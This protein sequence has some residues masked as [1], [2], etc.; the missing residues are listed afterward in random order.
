MDQHIVVILSEV[1]VSFVTK[2]LSGT[3]GRLSRAIHCISVAHVRDQNPNDPV[4]R[5]GTS[6]LMERQVSPLPYPPLLIFPEGTTTN[7]SSLIRFRTGAFI[8]RQPIQPIVLRY[9]Y[10]WVSPTWETIPFPLY[11]FQMLTQLTHRIDIDFL[12]LYTPSIEEMSDPM[13]YTNNIRKTM[14][15]SSHLPLSEASMD[16]KM[17]YH[18][19]IIDGRIS[20][21]DAITEL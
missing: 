15:D 21:R 10:N 16:D 13:L 4:R 14:A 12:P 9:K 18:R 11:I 6:K 17:A 5:N 19:A 1:Q 8:A 2:G 7:G 3:I 20:W